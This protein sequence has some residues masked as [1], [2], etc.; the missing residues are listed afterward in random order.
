VCH[1]SFLCYRLVAVSADAVEWA[2]LDAVTVF[3]SG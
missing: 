3:V 1:G 2:S